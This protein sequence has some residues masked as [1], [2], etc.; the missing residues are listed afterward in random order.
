MDFTPDFIPPVVVKVWVA[1][2]FP[3]R[4]IIVRSIYINLLTLPA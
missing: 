3:K 4:S 1:L 2:S